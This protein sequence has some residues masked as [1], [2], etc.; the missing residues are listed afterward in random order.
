[1]K[2]AVFAVTVAALS[3]AAM[4]PASAGDREWATAGKVLTGV[5]VAGVLADAFRPHYE[6][7]VVYTTVSAPAPVVYAPACPPTTV[8]YEA[9]APVCYTPAP[10]V[11]YVPAPVVYGRPVVYGGHWH[12]PHAVHGHYEGRRW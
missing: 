9:P 6:P 3:S 4:L 2:T 1:M 5:A 7:P 12:G 8:V 10:R 11:V